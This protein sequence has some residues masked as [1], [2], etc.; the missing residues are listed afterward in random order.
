MCTPAATAGT[1]TSTEAAD[2][3]CTVSGDTTRREFV[4]PLSS[5]F[6]DAFCTRI[7]TPFRVLA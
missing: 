7:S 4:W 3:I 1:A 6:P 5:R 2:T